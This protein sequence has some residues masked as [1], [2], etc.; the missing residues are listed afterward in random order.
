VYSPP[1]VLDPVFLPD[2]VDWAHPL[3]RGLRVWWLAPSGL[4][5]GRWWYDLAGPQHMALAGLAWD[6][7]ARLVGNGTN[8]YGNLSGTSAF[9]WDRTQPFAVSLW[10]TVTNVPSYVSLVGNLDTA[11][12]YRGW[13]LEYEPAS[14]LG[15]QLFLINSYPSNAINVR[16]AQSLPS[17]VPTHVTWTYDGSSTAAGC[18]CYVNGL[19]VTPLDVF[20]NTLSG[21][22]AN[23]VPLRIGQRLDGSCT[24]DGMLN[25]IR[26][27]DRVPG[28]AECR[29]QY[30]ESL[31]GYPTA[32]RRYG[33]D[34]P[35]LNPL[36]AAYWG[37]G[38]PHLVSGTPFGGS[39]S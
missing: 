15:L 6:S 30:I 21:P 26:I 24:H 28:A 18:S 10:V 4:D 11:G 25:D 9:N 3:N 5:G 2:P 13:E 36:P 22:S 7:T 23:A 1:D 32:L 31:L 19:P 34:F 12:G 29:D 38:V 20:Y 33:S 17:N 37:F 14:T 16:T 35:A 27:L 39:L 8:S